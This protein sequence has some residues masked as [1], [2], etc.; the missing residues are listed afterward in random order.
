MLVFEPGRYLA[1]PAGVLLAKIIYVKDSETRS[2][3]IVDAAMN[4][5]VRPAMYEAH[6]EI[7][8]V[9]DPDDGAPPRKYDIVGP[10]CET[11]DTF[12]T[13]RPL[14]EVGAGDLIVIRDAGAYGAVMASSYNSRPLIAE[15]LVRG[16]KFSMVRS[17]Q[18][19]ATILAQES[20][21]DWQT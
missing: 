5:L 17:R 16:D 12:G 21:A 19:I 18:D 1:G 20:F 13:E 3:A 6:H 2:F 11:G 14:P 15:V 10:I 9:R 7:M 4:D 8:P